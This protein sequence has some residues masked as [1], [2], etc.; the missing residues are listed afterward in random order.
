MLRPYP[1]TKR[2]LIAETYMDGNDAST[3]RR[4]SEDYLQ[5]DNFQVYRVSSERVSL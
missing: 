4:D 3:Q 1:S 5:V 2:T